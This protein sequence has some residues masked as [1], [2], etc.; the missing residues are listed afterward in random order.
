MIAAHYD[1]VPFGPG[2][3]DDG[4]GVAALLEIARMTQKL[5]AS[6]NDILF[7]ITD[8]EELGLLGAEGFVRSHA[9]AKT[10]RVA[11]N[12]EA[13]GTSGRSLMFQTS[14]QS[15]WLIRHY[16]N[17]TTHPTTSSLY[18]EVYKRLPNDTDFTVFADGMRVLTSPSFEM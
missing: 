3:S 9:L 12:L 1:S 6:R 15:A 13:R 4:A 14:D 18:Q 2:A 5:P 7:L 17:C 10:I 8:G 16:A 11:I